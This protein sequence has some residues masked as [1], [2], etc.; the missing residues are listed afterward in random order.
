MSETSLRSWSKVAGM[1]SAWLLNYDIE[2][3]PFARYFRDQVFRVSDLEKLHQSNLCRS[4]SPVGYPDNLRL[5]QWMQRLPLSSDFYAIYTGFVHQLVVRHFGGRISYAARPKMRVHLAGS[6]SVS[7]W[8]RDANVTGRLEQI[9]IWLPV[10]NCFAG[11]TLW[12][13][14]DYGTEHYQPI[15][16]RLG[17]ALFFDG[18]LLS[19]G[20]VA[21]ETDTSRV[22]FDLRFSPS[23][24]TPSPMTLRLLGER[25]LASI[26][27]QLCPSLSSS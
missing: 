5:R 25:P 9:N 11:N 16:V 6:G 1:Q 2:T 13:E 12:V 23:S 22:S 10:T 7:R 18:G 15:S 20:S 24:P 26:V 4:G 17:Q 19:H 21:N 14:D 8:H 3:Y 27:A